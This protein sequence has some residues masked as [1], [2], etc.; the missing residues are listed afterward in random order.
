MENLLE[1]LKEKKTKLKS[2]NKN[3]FAKIEKKDNKNIYHTKIFLDF[4]AFG[5]KK[6]QNYRFFIS[7]RKLLNREK[8][9]SFS[10]F[11]LK[12]EDKFLGIKYGCRK[13]IKNVLRKY[14]ENNELK[15]ATF[16]KIHYIQFKFKKGSIFCYIVGIS[17][18]LRKDKIKKKY[19]KSLIKVLLTLEKEIYEFYDKKLLNGGIITKWIEK[20]QK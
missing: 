16:S 1:K 12:N 3:I 2:E 4:H 13:P 14:K 15:T 5:I 7:L 18:L 17:Y 10:L 8:T 19:Y 6:N 11:S 9:E 20:E